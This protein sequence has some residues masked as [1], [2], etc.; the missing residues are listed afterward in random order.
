[1]RRG[2][3]SGAEPEEPDGEEPEPEEPELDDPEEEP[4]PETDCT[5]SSQTQ[6]VLPP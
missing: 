1:M 4:E 6:P 2:P 3:V 5:K